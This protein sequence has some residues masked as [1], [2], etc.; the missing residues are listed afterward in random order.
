MKSSKDEI[1]RAARFLFSTKGYH[2]TTIRDIA[3]ARGI[4]SGSLYAHIESKEDL[5]YAIVEEGATAFLDALIP[6]SQS[7]MSAL[8]KLQ[9]ALVAH[10]EVI[11]THMDGAR[12]FLHEW[13]ALDDEHRQKVLLQR[14]EYEKLWAQLLQEGIDTGVLKPVNVKYLRLLVLSAGNWVSEWY[15]SDGPMSPEMIASEF[16]TILLYGV[17][18]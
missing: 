14:D 7:D 1:F 11:T 9:A 16:L 4:L 5:L 15:R 12:V 6:I 18:E 8:N 13:T 10:I 3:K 17:A 2:G